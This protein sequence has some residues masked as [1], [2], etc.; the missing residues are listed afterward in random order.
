MAKIDTKKL[1]PHSSG[2]EKISAK[3]VE[4]ISIVA[5]TLIDVNTLLKGSLVLEEMRT[6]EKRLA[7]QKKRRER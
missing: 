5:S 3:S 7:A 1:L 4:D 2:A 6:K